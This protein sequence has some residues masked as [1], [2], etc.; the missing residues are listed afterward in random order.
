[1]TQPPDIHKDLRCS[2]ISWSEISFQSL[3]KIVRYIFRDSSVGIVTR[4]QAGWL[5]NHGLIC[6]RKKKVFF[7]PKSPHQLWGPCNLLFNGYKELFLR[8]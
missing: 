8:R 5:R 7:S 6:S 4:L 2:S 1:M 3:M